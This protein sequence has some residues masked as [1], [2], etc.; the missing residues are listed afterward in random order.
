MANGGVDP[1]RIEEDEAE[2]DEVEHRLAKKP[3]GGQNSTGR[4]SS[5]DVPAPNVHQASGE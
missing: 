3:A 5:E 1:R 2:V 4:S